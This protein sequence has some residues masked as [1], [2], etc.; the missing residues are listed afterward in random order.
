MSTVQSQPGRILS[1]I[2]GGAIVSGAVQEIGSD[3]IGVALNSAAASGDVYPLATE[4][5]FTVAK[6]T[7]Q[8][9]AAG[10]KLYWDTSAA[11]ASN[12]YVAA[13]ADNYIGLAT[14]IAASA[15]TTGNCK[16]RGGAEAE[17]DLDDVVLKSLF[18]AETILI[19]TS[20]NT[21]IPLTVS[22]STIVGR[23]AA[24]TIVA[25]TPAQARVVAATT[26][27]AEGDELLGAG[28]VGADRLVSAQ[29]AGALMSVVADGNVLG[30]IP[31]VHVIDIGATAGSNAITLTEKT[32]FFFFVAIKTDEDGLAG[33]TLTIKNGA[34]AITNAA[35]WDNT[36]ADKAIV[37][38]S[39][40]DD[41]F[42]AVAAAGSLDAVTAG[43][44]QARGLLFAFGVKRT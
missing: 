22:A 9:W 43:N 33:C 38:F 11:T 14:A 6:K 27:E 29:I 13:A 19:A 39:S 40:I 32:E 37:S 16:L 31:V 15:A 41:G 23:G 17:V 5:V 35:T 34:N 24:G 2:A 20:D 12:A 21:P 8:T 1:I 4:G 28:S 25:L 18:D 10:D 44:N 26:S 30:G 36:T 7:S 3:I 42:S